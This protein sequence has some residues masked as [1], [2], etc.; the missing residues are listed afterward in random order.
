MTIEEK[1]T[2]KNVAFSLRERFGGKDS[3]SAEEFAKYLGKQR[4]FVCQMVSARQLP[5]A[6]IGGTFIIPVDSIALW[7]ARLSKT[8][9]EKEANGLRSTFYNKTGL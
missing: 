2:V 5:G 6:K 4:Q 8:R 9:A 3:I 1:T 7:E